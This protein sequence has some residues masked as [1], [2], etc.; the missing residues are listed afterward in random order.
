M[1]PKRIPPSDLEVITGTQTAKKYLEMQ[2][3]AWKVLFGEILKTPHKINLL[4]IGPWPFLLQRAHQV[5][6]HQLLSHRHIPASPG[7]RLL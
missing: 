1:M 5:R 6:T 2:K 7:R 4:P 3:K